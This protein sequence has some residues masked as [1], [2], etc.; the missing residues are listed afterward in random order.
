[1]KLNPLKTSN[2]PLKR[3]KDK[4]QFILANI[5]MENTVEDLEKILNEVRDIK[6][7][8]KV[9]EDL[10]DTEENKKVKSATGEDVKALLK[11]CRSVAEVKAKVPEYEYYEDE[12]LV[13]CR[14]CSQTFKYDITTET[15]KNISSNLA[16]LKENLK[17]HL[18]SQIHEA[19]LLTA[20]NKEKINSKEENRNTKCG[21]NLCRT[22]YYILKNG[23]PTS[24]F[25]QL[26]SMQHRNGADMGEV[27]HSG[28]FIDNM[29][30]SISKV[31]MDRVQKHLG[32][33]LPQTGLLP[34]CKIVEDS[35]TYRHD[36][37]H[38]IGLTSIFP[39]NK[40]LL[41]SVFIGAPKG[42]Q[43]DGLSTAKC[44]VSTTSS[45]MKPQ[46]YLGTSVDGAN[47]L[48][49]VGELVDKEL[50]VKGHHDWDGVH[51]AA[52]KETGLRNPKK[53]WAK[54]FSWLNDINQI[55]SKAYKFI[56]WGMEWDRYFR[57][58][59]AM[60]EEGYEFRCKVP[61]FFSETRFGNYAAQIYDRF[62]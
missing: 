5:K 24:D 41:Q 43:S 53:P 27:N 42:I 6:V 33:R 17:K 55:I 49:H 15:G 26:I 7:A 54:E 30:G 58:F 32:T 62:R 9:V 40:P 61:K 56:N 20:D 29:A 19:S 38:L 3:I 16:H 44:M 23:Q 10:K 35:A 52:T 39:G 57:T 37:R 34:P 45:F 59:K 2:I 50:G 11:S 22:C 46:Q 47:F 8:G 28:F 18:D 48:S 13:N 4:V 12:D 1:M 51:A 14:V 25:P 36:T 31:F 60:I 21:M